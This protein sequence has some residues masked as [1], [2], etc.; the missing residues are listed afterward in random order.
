MTGEVVATFGGNAFDEAFEKGTSAV[1]QSQCAEFGFGDET[2]ACR[3][4][5]HGGELT[6][7]ADEHKTVDERTVAGVCHQEREQVRFEQL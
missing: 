6:V 7:V 1:G 2:F 5:Y 3:L 4:L